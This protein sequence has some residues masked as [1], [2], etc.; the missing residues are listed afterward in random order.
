MRVRRE[1]APC[2]G[3]HLPRRRVDRPH[4]RATPRRRR[5]PR[6][7]VHPR[8]HPRPRL[9]PRPRNPAST[10]HRP[11]PPSQHS[12]PRTGST[13]PRRTPQDPRPV[14][15]RGV[16][17]PPPRNRRRRPV[18]VAVVRG[19]AAHLPLPDGSADLIVTSPPYYGLR[20]YT[21]GGVH[22]AGQIG[23]EPTPVA[24][25]AALVECTREWVRVLKP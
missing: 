12:P 1:R 11:R 5:L 18:S 19:D 21:D 14:R 15:P 20:C 17:E 3:V 23:S 4:H 25:I 6:R 24:Y 16:V 13:D 7:P 8:H 9:P 2:R 10:P 22:Y